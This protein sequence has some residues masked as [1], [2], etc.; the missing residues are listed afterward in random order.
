MADAAIR[1][2]EPRSKNWRLYDS[3]GLMLE[4]QPVGGKYWRLK[5]Q[6]AGGEAPL[7]GNVSGVSV[8]EARERRDKA[9]EMLAAG[10]DPDA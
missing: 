5:C 10:V 1:I 8:S 4:V 3:L 6:V 2:A 7:A 9:R